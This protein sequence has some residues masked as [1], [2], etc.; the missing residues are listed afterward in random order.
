MR[1]LRSNTA[2]ERRFKRLSKFLEALLQI[3][4]PPR[5]VGDFILGCRLAFQLAGSPQRDKRR[6]KNDQKEKN[7]NEEDFVH[8]RSLRRILSKENL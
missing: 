5:Q 4:N 7:D 8:R 2:S 1:R 6:Y 3:V